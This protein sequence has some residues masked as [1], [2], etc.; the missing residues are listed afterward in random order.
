MRVERWIDRLGVQIVVGD[1][2]A[3]LMGAY[4]HGLRVIMLDERLAAT[5][6]LSTLAH[7]LGHAFYGH[8]STTA[9]GEREA[10]EWAARIL[11]SRR[12]F[13]EASRMHSGEVGVAHEL[14]VLPRDVR[15]Y[16]AWMRR[17]SS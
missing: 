3:G 9:R 4:L 7:E 2:G 5:Q 13:D 6:R 12:A 14:G 8:E 1:L 15:N 17:I 16:V 11:I 10:S